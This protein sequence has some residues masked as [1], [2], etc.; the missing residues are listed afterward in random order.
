VLAVV[1]HV[2]ASN[3]ADGVAEAL[4]GIFNL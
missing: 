4:A 2:T 1:D 3:D